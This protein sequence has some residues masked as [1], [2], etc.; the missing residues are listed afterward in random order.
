MAEQGAAFRQTAE[1]IAQHREAESKAFGERRR[2][3]ER[4]DVPKY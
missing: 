3:W 4:T 1:K 2:V